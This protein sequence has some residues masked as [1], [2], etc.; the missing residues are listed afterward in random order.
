MLINIKRP[1]DEYTLKLEVTKLTLNQT[2]ENDQFEL[3]VPA[4]VTVQQMK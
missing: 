2:L 4:G 1:L 3:K